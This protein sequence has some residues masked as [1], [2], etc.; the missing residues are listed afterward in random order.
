MTYK[1]RGDIKRLILLIILAQ[2]CFFVSAAA[3]DHS[4]ETFS[5]IRKNEHLAES[6]RL[7]KLARQAFAGG[8][9]DK[10]EKYAEDAIR[11]AMTSDMYVGSQVKMYTVDVMMENALERL[12]MADSA[13]I[14]RLYPDEF[15][16]AKT[17]YN[18]GLIAAEA[19]EWNV[20][21]DNAGKVIKT[22]AAVRLPVAAPEEAPVAEISAEDAAVTEALAEN[23]PKEDTTVEQTP[24]PAQYVV[25]SWE[26][27]GDCFWNIAGKSWVYGDPR[28]WP[29]LYN[30]NKKKLPDPNNPDLIEPGMVIDIPSLK[31]EKRSGI[32]NPANAYSPLNK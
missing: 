29:L 24:Y 7:Q 21:I 20:A 25:R 23:A 11:A 31:G 22:L 13:E 27:Y 3:T 17:Y 5:N 10:A 1:K 30:A 14:K 16:S 15:Y 32:W 4:G 8:Y 12:A 26:A 6:V 2:V 9:Y 18:L 28:R 19:R